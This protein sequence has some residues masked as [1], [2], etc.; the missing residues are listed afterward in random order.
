MTV[1]NVLALPLILLMALATPAF[2]D[3]QHIVNPGVLSTAVDQHVAQQDADRTAVRDALAQPEVRDAAAKIGLDLDRVAGSLATISGSDLTRA[4]DAARQVNQ[5]L[6]GGASTIT[7]QT[8]TII[9]VLLVVILI[10]VL[11]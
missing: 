11:K 5:Q 2:A 4:G 8:T 10:I 3:T 6:V 7:M 1:R 9:I